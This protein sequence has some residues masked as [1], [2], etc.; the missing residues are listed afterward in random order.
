MTGDDPIQELLRDPAITV[1]ELRRLYTLAPNHPA[2]VE[3][4]AL[5]AAAIAER[6]AAERDAT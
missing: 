2:L 4:N 3:L 5:I 1:D 6:V